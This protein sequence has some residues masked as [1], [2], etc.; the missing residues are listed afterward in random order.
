MECIVQKEKKKK[1]NVNIKGTLEVITAGRQ[2]LNSCI[3]PECQ[4]CC[5]FL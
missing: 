1:W 5:C 2:N 4:R 3:G